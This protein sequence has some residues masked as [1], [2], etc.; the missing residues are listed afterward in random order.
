MSEPTLALYYQDDYAREMDARLLEVRPDGLVLSQTV[1]YPRGGN[2]DCDRGTLT[3]R[4][5]GDMSLNVEEVLKD[6]AGTIT[7]RTVQPAPP[8][9]T[10]GLAVHGRLDWD[11][12]LTLTRLH[13]AQHL[14]SR[15]F[16]DHGDNGTTRVDILETGCII[17][18]ARPITLEQALDCEDDLNALIAA[19]RPVQ[20]IDT[21]GYLEIVVEAYDRQACGGTH[22]R[23]VSEIGHLAFTRVKGSRLELLC[24]PQ[25]N[26]ATRQ[27]AA[28]TLGLLGPL[29][30]DLAGFAPRVQELLQETAAQKAALFALREEV[31]TA[32][33]ARALETPHEVG[34]PE[35]TGL[36][37][38]VVDLSMVESKALPRLLKPA[39]APGRVFLCLCAG[40]N[41]VV[42]S[43][44]SRLPAAAVVAALKTRY[45]LS[46]GGS[47]AVAQCGP[48]PAATTLDEVLGVAAEVSAGG[49]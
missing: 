34:G 18:L 17:E 39:Q 7:H 23:D 19:G 29:E 32:R 21:D 45:G 43:G 25:A 14:I 6:E 48:L 35:Q 33:V 36:E 49:T 1:F 24:G 37:L 31:A 8:D 11:R 46:G 20:R 42:V 38:Y 4:N 40:R 41:L 3:G 47:P 16:L 27:M 2:Q 13:T 15:W 26:V 10:P 44:T 30:T 22:V 9:W 28:A 12:R 5:S